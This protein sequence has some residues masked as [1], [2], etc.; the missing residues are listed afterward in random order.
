M[1]EGGGVTDSLRLVVV[2]VPPTTRHVGLHLLVR[3][4]KPVVG[5]RLDELDDHVHRGERGDAVIVA[6]EAG[7]GMEPV[8][9]NRPPDLKT[10]RGAG[11]WRWGRVF[12]GVVG[13]H[14]ACGIAGVVGG[15]TPSSL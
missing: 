11:G 1:G 7:L 10:C 15:I 13:G 4:G 6:A 9:D 12:F 5:D 8:T 2:P 3:N 14:A